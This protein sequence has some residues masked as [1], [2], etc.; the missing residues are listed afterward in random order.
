MKGALVEV[1]FELRHFRIQKKKVDS[2][3]ATVQQVLILKPGVARPVSAFKRWNVEEGPMKVSAKLARK[4]RRTE[5]GSTIDEGAGERCM[6]PTLELHVLP[7]KTTS[8]D[9]ADQV[10]ESSAQGGERTCVDFVPVNNGSRSHA[11]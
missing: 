4:K 9:G 1:H 2:F 6:V 8:A 7:V 11:C 3:N 10:A 5:E